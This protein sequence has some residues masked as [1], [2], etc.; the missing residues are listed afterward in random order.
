[1]RK[2]L[3]SCYY[4]PLT[5]HT[6]IGSFLHELI[7][8]PFRV[9]TSECRWC[10]SGKR[11]PRHHRFTECEAW[12]PQIRRLWRDRKGLRVEAPKGTESKEVVE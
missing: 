7:T 6:A 10:C 2:P 3:A 12:R 5:G 8:G 4:Q 11:E 9:E 1:M